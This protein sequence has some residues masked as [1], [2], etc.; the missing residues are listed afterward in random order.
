MNGV[1]KGVHVQYVCASVCVCMCMC[2]ECVAWRQ[3]RAA[4][5]FTKLCVSHSL[6]VHLSTFFF[7]FYFSYFFP[8]PFLHSSL[9]SSTFR[10]T[11]FILSPLFFF[12]FFP[13]VNQPSQHNSNQPLLRNSTLSLN[14]PVKTT[15]NNGLNKFFFFCNSPRKR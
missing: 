5:S 4:T 13:F 3:L 8:F 2:P 11:P 6:L 14:G 9:P 7:F 12:S 10:T 15:S 1:K